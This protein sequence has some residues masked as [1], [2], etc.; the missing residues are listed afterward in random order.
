MVGA[1]SAR[2]NPAAMLDQAGLPWFAELN[3]SLGDALDGAGFQARM[4]RN[5]ALLDE[6]AAEILAR[7]RQALPA[8]T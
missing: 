6:L 8:M 7:A 5:T 3:R 4:R 2:R 1:R